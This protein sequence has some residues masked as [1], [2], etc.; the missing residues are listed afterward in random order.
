MIRA[1]PRVNVSVAVVQAGH[2]GFAA[3]VEPHLDRMY[4]LALR[5]SGERSAAEDI[6]QDALMR[7]Y[8]ALGQLREP[9][10]AQFWLTKIVHS[11]WLDRYR[12]E[13]DH[14][15]DLSID[16]ERYSLFDTLAEEDPFPYSDRLHLDFLELFDDERLTG[17]LQA[18]HPPNRTA[19]V[20]AYVYG[21][22]AREVAELTGTTVGTVLARLHRGRKQLER[23]LWRYATE[24]GLLKR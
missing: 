13:A 11:A 12:K 4:S 2:A 21:Y 19:L 15:R 17:A 24:C 3:L 1:Y 8:R 20:L 6:V 9:D 23:G 5:L 7:A 18:M 22:K 16:D 14:D 10:R